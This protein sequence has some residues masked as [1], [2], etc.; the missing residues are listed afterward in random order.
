M[1]DKKSALWLMDPSS[2]E[3]VQLSTRALFCPKVFP[4]LGGKAT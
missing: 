1:D 3:E 2:L 4:V